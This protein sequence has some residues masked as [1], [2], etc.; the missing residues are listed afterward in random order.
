[1]HRQGA[2]G[3]IAAPHPRGRPKESPARGRGEVEDRVQKSPCR[4][5]GA[6]Y[7]DWWA[8]STLR[9]QKE[10]PRERR[11]QS[12]IQSKII[13]PSAPGGRRL[14]CRGSCPRI[15]PF[16]AGRDKNLLA[17]SEPRG[18]NHGR[19]QSLRS[20]FGGMVR[21]SVW[22]CAYRLGGLADLAAALA[23]SEGPG[24]GPDATP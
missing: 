4:R 13:H 19:G 11:G 20:R 12:L 8:S 15:E 9:A 24:A 21:I 23:A 3:E 5:R 17:D 16:P 22:L 1:M 10:K 7:P 18:K 14:R 6:S 2:I